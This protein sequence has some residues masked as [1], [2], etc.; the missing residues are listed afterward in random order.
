VLVLTAKVS[1]N[2]AT[3]YVP[4]HEPLTKATNSIPLRSALFRFSIRFRFHSYILIYL[5]LKIGI[6]LVPYCIEIYGFLEMRCR[7][8]LDMDFT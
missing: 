4:M 6:E 5:G 1:P 7:D 2:I 3:M 8:F